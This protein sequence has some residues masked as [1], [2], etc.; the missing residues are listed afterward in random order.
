[1]GREASDEAYVLDLCNEALGET[2]QRQARFDWLRGDSGN[3]RPGR[4]LPV[5]GYWPR[6][7]LVVEYRERQHDIPV[8]HFDKPDRLTVS[9]VH[10][11]LQRALYDR[12]REDEIPAHGLR[13]VVIKPDDL[14]ANAQGRLRRSHDGD[15]PLVQ[16]LL[17]IVGPIDSTTTDGRSD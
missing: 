12:R 11:G 13:L 9:G 7:R 3:D 1:M 14:D 17:G 16:A 6:H 4:R 15:L 5:D 10:R 8:P 2:A